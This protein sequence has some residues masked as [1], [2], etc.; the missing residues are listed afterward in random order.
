MPQSILYDND[1]CLVSRI[2]PDGTRQ[3]TRSFSGL[4]SHYLFEDR[5]GRPGKGNDKGN[6]EGVVGFA[7]RNFMT[8]RP[9]F[10]NW[11]AFI[12]YLE[13]QCQKRQG[14]VLRGH[15]ESIGE[16][17]ARD[18]ETLAA[19]PPAPFDACDKQG[20]RVNSLSLVRYRTNDYSVPVAYGHQEVWI[21]ETYCEDD[22]N[23]AVAATPDLI[24]HV[25][26]HKMTV[27]DGHR[28]A[29][30]LDDLSE[31]ALT[32]AV[33]LG[34]SH[35]GSSDN[36]ALTREQNIN[37][38]APARPPKGAVS[39]RLTLE[40]FTLNEEGLVLRCPNN[41][42]PVSA[43]LA[44]AKLQARFDLSICQKCPD[45]L[46]CP[47]QAAKRDGQFSRFQY[48]PARAANQKRRLYEQSDAF[49]N[50]YRWR[51]GIEATMSRLK[52]QMNLAH[53]RIRGMPAMRYVVNL[54]ALGLNIRRCAAIAP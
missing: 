49:R 25:E 53:L 34:D 36:M 20:T 9:R 40:D 13:E 8:P 44:K 46:R 52:Y 30:A 3:R 33:M 1:K 21:V 4:Q 43:S 7:R 22:S 28:L 29:D 50:V 41:V 23:E 6:V 12:A 10:V 54:R 14:D 35:Y 37:L 31:R 45:I 38:V 16:R 27:H 51:A 26:V 11:D 39:G 15:R 2:L 42:E 5:Y 18:H 19:L 48:T 24:T 17:F 47:V 32:P